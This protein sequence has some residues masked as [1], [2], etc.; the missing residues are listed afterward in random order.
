MTLM[1]SILLIPAAAAPAEEKPATRLEV[2]PMSLVQTIEFKKPAGARNL[3]LTN[4]RVHGRFVYAHPKA[5]SQL[6]WFRRGDDGKLAEAGSMPLKLDKDTSQTGMVFVRDNLYMVRLS[7]GPSRGQRTTQIVWL[8][9]DPKTGKPTEKAVIDTSAT[10]GISV[11]YQ[12]LIASADG[13]MLYLH[14]A[15]GNAKV[16]WL[17]LDDEG[18]PTLGGSVSGDGIGDGAKLLGDT[19]LR[20]SPDGKHLYAI[21]GAQHKIGILSRAEDGSLSHVG[22]VDLSLVVKKP[23]PPES[24][25]WNHQFSWAGL[26]ISPDGKFVYAN[27]WAYGG[28][29]DNVIGLFRRDAGSGKL[30]FIEKLK[31]PDALKGFSFA[32]S[33]DGR[34][35]YFGQLTGPA[36]HA[37]RDPVTGRL[38]LLK[39]FPAT[40]GPER[41]GPCIYD[42]TLD[43]EAGYAYF[44]DLYGKLFVFK[45]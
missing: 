9:V 10:S 22:A 25:R 32:I 1:A 5:L 29:D 28:K 16:A 30:A 45:L 34:N 42:M 18:K 12:P 37:K 11:S 40:D 20:I 43:A 15:G 6:V 21:T 38:T 33:P 35:A 13:K 8:K 36:T 2:Q 26:A 39:E 4:V 24:T 14:A 3:G 27:L 23:G 7:P 44:A 17:N 31:W 19:S 41:R